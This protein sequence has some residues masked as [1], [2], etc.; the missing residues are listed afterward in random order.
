VRQLDM[1]L[2][3]LENS[4]PVGARRLLSSLM[5]IYNVATLAEH[6]DAIV[7]ALDFVFVGF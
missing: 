4:E 7:A 5:R 2:E 6:R 3:N 1:T